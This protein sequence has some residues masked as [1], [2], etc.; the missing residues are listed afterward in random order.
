[1]PIETV[2]HRDKEY[3]K[4]QTNGNA[5]RFCM[6]FAKEVCKGTGFDIGYSKEEWKL[7]GAWGIEPSINPSFD[8]MKLPDTG[9]VDYIFS[10]HCLEHTYN[11]VEVL[12]YWTSRIKPEGVLFL[13][14]PDW[15]Q[16]YW[17]PFSNYKHLHIFKPEFIRDY[18][19][20]SGKYKNIFV[21]GV[22]AYNSF[23][24]MAERKHD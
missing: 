2:T 6:P 15:S 3:P 1:M 11:W 12:D 9:L 8:A 24:A 14:L 16:T 20:Q 18:L 19:E 13:Y 7:P 22:D 5:A 10:S 17:R 23:I 4:F 21:S